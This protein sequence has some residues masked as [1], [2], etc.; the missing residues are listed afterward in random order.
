MVE[1]QQLPDIEKIDSKDDI[2]CLKWSINNG[3]TKICFNFQTDTDKEN[4]IIYLYRN[5]KYLKDTVMELKLTE[6][7]KLLA[8]R[9]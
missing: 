8:R 4:T 1:T 3:R 2:F 9:V 6:H 7:K 5:N